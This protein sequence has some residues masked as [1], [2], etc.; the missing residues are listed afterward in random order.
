VQLDVYDIKGSKVKT[1]NLK[2]DVFTVPANESLVHQ[3]MVMQRANKRLGTASTKTRAVVK[4]SSKKLYA[5]KHTGRARR[6]AAESPVMVGGGVAFGPH[7]RSYRQAMP[8]KMKKLAIKCVL[9]NKAGSGQ[10]KIVDKFDLKQPRTRDLLD[11]LIALGI[12]STVLIA[13]TGKDETLIKSA[14]NLAG[15]ETISANLLNVL[16]ML[17][18][19]TLLM[20]EEAVKIVEETWGKKAAEKKAVAKTE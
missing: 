15:V 11:A 7:P 12:D 2:D 10:L 9:S 13:T 4:R 20:S 17:S 6:G 8:K 18:Y 19:K 16:D 14:M 5:Q 1:I 3:A